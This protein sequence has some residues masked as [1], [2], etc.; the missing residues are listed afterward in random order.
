LVVDPVSKLR[1]RFFVG[2][3]EKNGCEREGGEGN[4]P[5]TKERLLFK[6]VVFKAG[7]EG[8]AGDSWCPWCPW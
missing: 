2:S 6:E 4:I 7:I 3:E 8:V 1:I 5:V